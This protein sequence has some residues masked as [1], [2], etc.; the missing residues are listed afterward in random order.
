MEQRRTNFTENE[1]RYSGTVLFRRMERILFYSVLPVKTIK[2][3]TISI[4][5]MFLS[6]EN[7]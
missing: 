4:W 1:E 6:V 3:M 5:I 7:Y 2:E